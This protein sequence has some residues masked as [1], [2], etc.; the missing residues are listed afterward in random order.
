GRGLSPFLLRRRKADVLAE[1]PPRIEQ[2]IHVVL[3]DA[4]RRLYDRVKQHYRQQ[5]LGGANGDWRG[6]EDAVDEELEAPS[7]NAKPAIQIFAALMR[8]RQLAV[9]PALLD[10]CAIDVGSA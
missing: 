1:L 7:R 8:L 5:L 9:H 4:Q 2:T 3:G 10:A 6:T